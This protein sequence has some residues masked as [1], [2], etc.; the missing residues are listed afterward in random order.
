MR[1]VLGQNLQIGSG[2]LPI[3]VQREVVGR[4]DLAERD[5]RLQLLVG[6]YEVIA[7]GQSLELCEQ[8]QTER[9]VPHSR[10]QCCL[11][12]ISSGSDRDVGR[13]AAEILAEAAHL[14]EADTVLER[15][16]ID[17]EAPHR[18]NLR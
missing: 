7:Y 10:E 11:V 5:R 17:A 13:T 16:Q 8:V 3:E 1:Y 12:S 18:Q 6:A 14:G 9:V 15:I 4:K 2:R